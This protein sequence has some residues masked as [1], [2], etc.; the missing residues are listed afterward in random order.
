[1]QSF[2]HNWHVL[3]FCRSFSL[4]EDEGL[5][6]YLD[7]LFVPASDGLS[8]NRS[9]RASVIARARTAIEEIRKQDDL[10]ARLIKIY[11]RTSSYDYE[12]LEFLLE[13][14]QKLDDT[15]D[16]PLEK[17]HLAGFSQP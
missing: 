15:K 5:L 10:L 16:I 1:M 14:M 7:H 6:L 13:T 2:I 3:Y 8:P 17:V 9:S 4:D 11:Y 12:T